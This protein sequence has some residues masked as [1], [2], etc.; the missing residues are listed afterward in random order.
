[1]KTR[2]SPNFLGSRETSAKRVSEFSLTTAFKGSRTPACLPAQPVSPRRRDV[3]LG[4]AVDAASFLPASG[5]PRTPQRSEITGRRKPTGHRPASH[6]EVSRPHTGQTANRR[7][8]GT[9]QALPSRSPPT[10]FRTT[11]GPSRPPTE[12][13]RTVSIAFIIHQGLSRNPTSYSIR[14]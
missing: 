14:P 10:N 2:D 3:P 9:R 4:M 8:P 11:P 6:K 12:P 1:M 13:T 5:V 7:E